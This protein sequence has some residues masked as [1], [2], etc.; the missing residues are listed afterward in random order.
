M[1]ELR[2]CIGCGEEKPF[3][4]FA[5]AGITKGVQ[6]RRRL[7]ASCY[8]K[9]KYEKSRENKRR[10][11]EYK[12]G[13]SCL[14]CGNDDHR[15]IEFHHR[16]PSKKEGA[17]SAMLSHSW[18]KIKREIDKCDALC[19]NCHRILHYELRNGTEGD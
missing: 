2:T 10:L 15:V 18:P 11:V 14:H 4:K 3:G 13:L 5:N 6:Y 16:D 19:A 7:C 1:E 9:K 8:S 12:G 17:I